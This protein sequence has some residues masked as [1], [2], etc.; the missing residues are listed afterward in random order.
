VVASQNAMKFSCFLVAS[1]TRLTEV[2]RVLPS[3]E[4]TGWR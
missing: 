4:K 3:G 2:A 1:L